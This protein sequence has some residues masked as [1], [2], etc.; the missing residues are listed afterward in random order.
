ME[1]LILKERQKFGALPVPCPQDV[2]NSGF[3][4]NEESKY[5]AGSLPL[6]AFTFP[7][8]QI[9]PDDLRFPLAG[10]IANRDLEIKDNRKN[11]CH[12]ATAFPAECAR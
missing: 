4:G 3:A 1:M 8:H 7:G 2:G 6:P 10:K 5:P 9:I 11:F 12:S